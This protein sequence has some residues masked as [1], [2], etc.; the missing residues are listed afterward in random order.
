MSL[1][2]LIVFFV[3]AAVCLL[4]IKGFIKSGDKSYTTKDFLCLLGVLLDRGFDGGTLVLSLNNSDKFLQYKKYILTDGCYGVR[5]DF[6]K[7]DWSSDYFEVLRGYLI[8]ESIDYE[9]VVAKNENELGFISVN[10]KEDIVFSSKLSCYVFEKIMD[11]DEKASYTACYENVSPWNEVIKSKN[12]DL[13][14][15][16][17]GMKT[18]KKGR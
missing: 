16:K 12:P 11:A 10:L 15:M 2:Y 6:P 17:E 8:T 4:L 3:V 9:E 13:L 5:M 1:F 7:A 14:T 18:I